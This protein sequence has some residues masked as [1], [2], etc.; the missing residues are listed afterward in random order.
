MIGR[1]RTEVKIAAALAVLLLVQLVHGRAIPEHGWQHATHSELSNARGASGPCQTCD[2][3][4]LVPCPDRAWNTLLI[5]G[6]TQ[7]VCEVDGRGL[8]PC[9]CLGSAWGCTNPMQS[10]W[11]CRWE[12]STWWVLK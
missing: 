11:D 6:C 10:F 3:T 8:V 2:W 4:A 9:G 1:M 12:W 5:V 7:L